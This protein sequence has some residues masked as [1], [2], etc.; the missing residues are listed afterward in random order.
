MYVL[1][2][3]IIRIL[4][5]LALEEKSANRENAS[6]LISDLYGQVLN[7]REVGSGFDQI[8]RQL[9][10]L[11]LDTPDATD[12]VGNFIARAVADDCLPPVYVTKPLS[13]PTDP[14]MQ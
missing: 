8:L 12:A 3:Q 2:F 14:K 4:I 13:S 9:S 5:T 1:F 6:V 11:E 7:S 10:D